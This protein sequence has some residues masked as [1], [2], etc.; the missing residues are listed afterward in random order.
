[1]HRI[2]YVLEMFV[3]ND[4]NWGNRGMEKVQYE[5][6]GVGS[7]DRVV[8]SCY[9]P[10]AGGV[11]APGKTRLGQIGVDQG[12]C[13]RSNSWSRRSRSPPASS[14]VPAGMGAS[15]PMG[16]SGSSRDKDGGGGVVAAGAAGGGGGGT[17]A[18]LELNFQWRC[19]KE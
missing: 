2:S 19:E 18:V 11:E 14:G 6:G 1:M 15:R 10:A 13:G 7:W 4:W 17:D 12:R 8:A 3:V 5:E 16:W 9:W